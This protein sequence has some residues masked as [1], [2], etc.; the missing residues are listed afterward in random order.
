MVR[1]VII[2]D[3]TENFPHQIL[4]GIH[5]YSRSHD[6][7]AVCKM[8]VSFKER[9]GLRGV[10]E[11]AEKWGA[12]VIIG[13]FDPKED[14]DIFRRHGI[15][16]VAQDYKKLFSG[17][18]NITSDYVRTGEMAA[19]YFLDNHFR[20]FAFYGY[21]DVVWSDE[22]CRGFRN[23]IARHGFEDSFY[24]YDKVELGSLWSL[25]YRPVARWLRSLPKQL[26]LM[27]CDDNQGTKIAEICRTGGIRVPEDI[28][29]LGV[30]ND[31]V[32]CT[33]TTDPS[34]S[35]VALDIFNAGI[36]TAK[37][38]D[39]VLSHRIETPYNIYIQPLKIVERASTEIF[40]TSDEAVLR[41]IKFIHRSVSQ[42]ISVEDVTR[43]AAVSRRLLETRFLKETGTTVLKFINGFKMK[44][45]ATLLTEHTTPI[46]D[47]V[48][49][50]GEREGRNVSRKFK[51][52][53]GCTPTEYRVQH[54]SLKA[55]ELPM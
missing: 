17:I 47:L 53:Y 35:S 48:E 29:L 31:E 13:T 22:R 26:A 25:D 39:D 33:L 21:H 23:E 11:W 27:A 54:S 6:P 12:N 46:D 45:L 55:P 41:A 44:T 37:M 50:I 16:A 2:S 40:P 32:V 8:P 34:M 24:K 30:D 1:L 28:A 18:A 15:L 5:S 19:R 9:N 20:H 49:L 36:Q 10:V 3:F 38:I 7:W 42:P 43:E 14:V 52:V 4:G 51:Q